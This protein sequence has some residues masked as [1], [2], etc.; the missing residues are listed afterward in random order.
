M[1]GGDGSEG[2]GG[3]GGWGREGGDEGSMMLARACVRACVCVCVCAAEENGTWFACCP[4][5]SGT[6]CRGGGTG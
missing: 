1:N 3:W 6:T 2:G 4:D 5:K